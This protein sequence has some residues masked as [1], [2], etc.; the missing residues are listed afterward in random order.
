MVLGK[1][2][3]MGHFRD[4]GKPEAKCVALTSVMRYPK[5]WQLL[6]N[7]TRW[8]DPGPNKR[9]EGNKVSTTMCFH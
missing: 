6:K 8:P 1:R 2:W 5:L 4:A 9:A 7:H 3:L